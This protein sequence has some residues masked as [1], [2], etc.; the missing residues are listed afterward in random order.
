MREYVDQVWGWDE[1]F[2]VEMFAGW[3]D[4]AKCQI[5]VVDGQ[6]AGILTVERRPNEFFLSLI[7]I[8]PAFQGRGLGS[9]AISSM[10]SQARVERVPAALQ[11]LK[12]NPA[13]RLYERLGFTIVGETATHHLMRASDL[14]PLAEQD[15]DPGHSQTPMALRLLQ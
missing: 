5:I 1:T 3:F 9:A 6:D 15:H 4:P 10:L 12:V 7:E 11:V 13:R 2:Q 14:V 8:L